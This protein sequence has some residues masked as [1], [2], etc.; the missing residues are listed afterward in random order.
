MGRGEEGKGRRQGKKGGEGRGGEKM[1]DREED[2]RKWRE[3][4]ERVIA[5]HVGQNPKY[6]IQM[7]SQ[8]AFITNQ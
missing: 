2:R 5:I 4:G 7:H 8:K 6:F 1:E 3:K